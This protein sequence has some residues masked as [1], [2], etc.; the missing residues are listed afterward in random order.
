[1][2]TVA[3]PT[4]EISVTMVRH[5]ASAGES[6]TCSP[7]L[8]S[9]WCS[10]TEYWAGSGMHA[11]VHLR[12]DKTIYFKGSLEAAK[13]GRDLSTAPSA[14]RAVRESLKDEI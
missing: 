14:H 5:S 7:Y 3:S 8:E 10:G 6:R 2:S 13:A 4:Y 11:R 9:L 1:M 12:C